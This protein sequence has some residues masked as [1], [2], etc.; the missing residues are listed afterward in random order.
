METICFRINP[1]LDVEQLA[2]AYRESGRVHIKE[3]LS[4][5][6]AERL[7]LSLRS[8]NRWRLIFNQDQKLFELDEAAQAD[9]TPEKKEQLELAVYK[10]ARDGFQF[11]YQSIRA[12]DSAAARAA[13][14]TPLNLFAG[15]LST[16]P[17]RSFLR[18]ITGEGDI[19]FADAQATAYGLKHFLTAHT[20][21]VEGKNRRAAYVLSLTPQWCIDWGGLLLFHGSDGHVEQAFTPSFNALNLFKVPQP[22]SVSMVTPFA[23]IRRYSITGWLRS[24]NQPG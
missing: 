1:E 18:S 22:H 6:A 13:D 8:S 9:L 17:A 21:D 11:I 14:P 23:A 10:G 20:D 24:G 12:P 2:A 3:F 19:S 15:F 5:D 4:A 16:E 7:F